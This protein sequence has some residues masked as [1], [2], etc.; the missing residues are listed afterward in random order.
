MTI[1]TFY[2]DPEKAKKINF[3]FYRFFGKFFSRFWFSHLVYNKEDMPTFEGHELLLKPIYCGICGTDFDKVM[4]T[5]KLLKRNKNLNRRVGKDY[6]GHEVV[7]EIIDTK[8]KEFKKNIGKRVIVADINVCKSFN[9]LNEC[10]NCKKNRGVFCLNKKK[11]IFKS[12]TYGGFSEFFVRSKYQTFLLPEKIESKKGIFVE[13]ISLG[14]NCARYLEDN[15]KILGIGISTISILFYR[16]LSQTMLDK[17]YFLAETQK[18]INICKKLNIKN[19]IK[20]ED[21][22]KNINYFD[23]ILDFYGSSSK[24]NKYL[25][26]LKP[27]SKIYL[28]GVED[29]KLSLNYHQIIS[30][31]ISVHGIHGYS[32]QYLTDQKRYKTDIERSIE[33]LQSDK[34]QVDDLI[35]NTI[36]QGEVKN[37]FEDA[38]FERSSKK[39][40]PESFKFRTIV[41]NI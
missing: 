27:K 4:N 40:N 11:R 15:K 36:D 38:C 10:D 29:E 8:D 3:A 12:N 28:F 23:S 16:T 17:F 37:Y 34:I 13:P 1:R 26:K 9:I 18:D 22:E 31:E 2:I 39:N 21:I 35:S 24:L 6:L 25:L 41:K 30:N 5:S 14:I 33:I 7:A 32:S 20:L 19:I